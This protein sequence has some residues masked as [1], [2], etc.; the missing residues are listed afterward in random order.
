MARVLFLLL[1]VFL[2]V[3]VLVQAQEGKGCTVKVLS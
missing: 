3:L 1:A 2:C